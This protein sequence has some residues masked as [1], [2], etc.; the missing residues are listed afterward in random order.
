MEFVTRL[1][2]MNSMDRTPDYASACPWGATVAGGLAFLWLFDW[3]GG[4]MVYLGV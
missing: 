1:R 3:G 4:C 2:G